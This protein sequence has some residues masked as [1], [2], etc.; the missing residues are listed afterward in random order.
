MAILEDRW[1]RFFRYFN[2]DLKSLFDRTD[3]LEAPPVTPL[4]FGATVAVDAGLGKNKHFRLVL[5]GA[6]TQLNNPINL[7]DGQKLLFEIIQDAVGSR[8]L[9][10]DTKYAFGTDII[11][12]TPTATANK[13]D[14]VMGTYILALDKILITAVAKGY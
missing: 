9:T 4:V 14:F 2:I 5:T 8:A 13:R 3:S 1:S 7:V 10:F 6:T 12:Y 11:S